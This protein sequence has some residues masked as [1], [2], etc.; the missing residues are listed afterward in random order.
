MKTRKTLF[1]IIAV[2]GIASSTFALTS[3]ESD[4]DDVMEKPKNIVEVAVSNSDFSTL[5][6]ALQKAE[7]VTALQADG[8]YSICTNQCSI[9]PICSQI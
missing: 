8:H 9:Q 2:L 4:D 3:C 1:T 7:L 6:A 5:V